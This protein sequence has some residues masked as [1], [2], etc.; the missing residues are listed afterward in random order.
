MVIAF[1]YGERT[2]LK[3]AL[4]PTYPPP[5]RTALTS[6]GEGVALFV[7]DLVE[8]FNVQLQ[9]AACDARDSV[10]GDVKRH[11]RAGRRARLEAPLVHQRFVGVT[12]FTH[13]LEKR[14]IKI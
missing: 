2:T 11:Q 13:C 3:S 4:A 5:T 7:R 9:R 10:G 1:V 12:V 6:D 14:H 8:V